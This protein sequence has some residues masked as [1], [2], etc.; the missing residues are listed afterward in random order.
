MQLPRL[1]GTGISRVHIKAVSFQP[2]LRAANAGNSA[3][4]SSVTVKIALAMS[5][6]SS[7]LCRTN[8][9]NNSV[10]AARISSRSLRSTVVAPRIP[11]QYIAI[12]SPFSEL[13]CPLTNNVSLL[14]GRR[15]AEADREW[16]VLVFCKATH[17]LD[18][19]LQVG[20]QPVA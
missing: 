18:E 4:R 2:I 5:S 12:T 11:R 3:S 20:W 8:N 19:V 10:V 17:A 6:I 14:Y 16:K 9:S 15:E 1:A 13:C 7:S